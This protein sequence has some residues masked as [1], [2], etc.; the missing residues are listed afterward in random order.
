MRVPLVVNG[1]LDPIDP[2]EAQRFFDDAMADLS[3]GGNLGVLEK[4]AF[5]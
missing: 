1:A 4:I 2:A 3:V 5:D